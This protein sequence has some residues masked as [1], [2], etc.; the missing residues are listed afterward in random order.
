MS[1]ERKRIEVGFPLPLAD[2]ITAA[3][4]NLGLSK[5]DFIRLAVAAYL[6]RWKTAVATDLIPPCD[7]CGKRHDKRDH[8]GTNG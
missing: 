5:P 2:Q 6:K 8:Y 4:E 7:I 1:K 3:A